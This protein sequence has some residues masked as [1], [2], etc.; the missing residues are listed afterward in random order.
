MAETLAKYLI[1]VANHFKS[2]STSQVLQLKKIQ[3]KNSVVQ[4]VHIYGSDL[5]TGHHLPQ[6]Q[7]SQLP[8]ASR[9]PNTVAAGWA[10]SRYTAQSHRLQSLL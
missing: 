6:T 7:S 8:T 3:N 1:F 4:T 2:F 10:G 9:R 5:A